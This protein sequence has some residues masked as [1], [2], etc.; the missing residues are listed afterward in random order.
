MSR[1]KGVPLLPDGDAGE[2]PD[3]EVCRVGAGEGHDANPVHP[4]HEVSRLALS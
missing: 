3:E 2:D 1:N 4:E